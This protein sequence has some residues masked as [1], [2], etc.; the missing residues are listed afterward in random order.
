MR[1]I[2][3]KFNQIFSKYKLINSRRD[4]SQLARATQGSQMA[5]DYLEPLLSLETHS[6]LQS[7]L[8]VSG[9]ATR[10]SEGH[11]RFSEEVRVALAW[12]SRAL[13]DEF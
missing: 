8:G 9:E 6:T 4:Y 13:S 12:L 11:I 5:R 1:K 10:L 7:P 3:K 2:I